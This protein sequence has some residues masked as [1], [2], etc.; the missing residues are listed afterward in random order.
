MSDYSPS[1]FLRA[2]NAEQKRIA[3][4]A[5]AYVVGYLLLTTAPH[6]YLDF[7]HWDVYGAYPW[8][9]FFEWALTYLLLLVVMKTGGYFAEGKTSGIGTYFV[10][11]LVTGIA[12]ILAAIVFILPGLYLLMRWLPVFARVLTAE[13]R[14]GQA[15]RWSWDATEH[16][17]KP[18]SLALLGPALCYAISLAAALSYDENLLAYQLAMAIMN[19]A[20]NL[21]SVWLTILGVAALG[22]L[23]ELGHEKED[24][25]PTA[26]P[27]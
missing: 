10:L 12:I 19:F 4:R 11:G 24:L 6:T 21:G 18:L 23:R 3:V 27:A 25:D 26:E 7:Y 2:L 14:I 9:G 13:E 8:I 22:M 20:L 1:D 5:W 17:Q 16:F 15:M